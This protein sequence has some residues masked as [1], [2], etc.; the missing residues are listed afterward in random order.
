MHIQNVNAYPSR[1]R[2]WLLPFRGIASRYLSP[3]FGWHWAL[4]GQRI[5]SADAFLG[6]APGRFHT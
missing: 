1:M 5:A 2:A 6:A 4:D 3:Y